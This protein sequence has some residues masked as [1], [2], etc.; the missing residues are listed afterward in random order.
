VREVI[1]NVMAELDLTLGLAGYA[2]VRELSRDAVS[3]VAVP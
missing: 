2:S 1:Q 3:R